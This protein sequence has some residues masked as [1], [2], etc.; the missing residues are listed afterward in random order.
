MV[1]KLLVVVIA[2]LVG[3]AALAGVGSAKPKA[4]PT[5]AQIAISNPQFS[6]LVSLAQAA[7]IAGALADP[8][9][10]LTVFAPT[11]DAFTKL[12]AAIP[13]VTKALTDPAN[14]A[15]LVQVLQHH[16][17]SGV[18]DS[19]AAI[20]AA[21]TGAQVP[22]LLGSDANGKLTLALKDGNLTV[23]D[24]AGFST[25]TVTTAD[26]K[27]SN[28]VIHVVDSV[29]VPKSVADALRKAGLIKGKTIVDVAAG[30]KNLSTLVTLVKAAGLVGALSSPDAQ[31]T[32]FAPR[33]HAF[34][35]LEKAI[36]GV[37]KALTDPKN[38]KLLV[39][40]LKY[41]VIASKVDSTAAIA[42]AKKNASVATLLGSNA[43]GKV[44][45]SLKGSK[46][47]V[48]DSARFST[49]TV[50]K[51][52]V[53]SSNGVIHVVDK[54]LVPKSVAVALKKAGLIK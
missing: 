27:A 5:I 34:A 16:A 20:D 40:V 33:N 30:N 29:L 24:S 45:L 25:A 41:H 43:N 8:N 3:V 23:T 31:L 2:A 22:T 17:L 49:A 9:A 6:T 36:P 12:E 48:T 46:L 14:K 51:A 11:N 50:T 52:D 38:K 32:V 1:K 39:Q 7:G 13:G 4:D 42:A 21:K 44:K 18:I 15:L 54:V 35:A 37:T 28:G 19:T 26:I 10:K 47:Q 53:S